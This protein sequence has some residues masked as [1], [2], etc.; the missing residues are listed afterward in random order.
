MAICLAEDLPKNCPAQDTICQ[1][2]R[3]AD[4]AA[5]DTMAIRLA[6][7]TL[8]RLALIKIQ[9]ARRLALIKIQHARQFAL[10]LILKAIRLVIDT[11]LQ[12]ICRTEVTQGD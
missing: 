6:K 7:D 9:C 4:F 1:A 3:L 10:Q 11:I 2:I 8:R 12:A 5:E